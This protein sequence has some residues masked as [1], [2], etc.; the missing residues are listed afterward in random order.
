MSVCKRTEVVRACVTVRVRTHAGAG[1]AEEGAGQRKLR[2]V[3]RRLL[4]F[5]SRSL[6]PNFTL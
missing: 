3:E 2:Q 5:A 1:A 6:I 4:P